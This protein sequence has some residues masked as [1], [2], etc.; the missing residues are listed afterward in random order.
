MHIRG[1]VLTNIYLS[2]QKLSN[3][4]KSIRV[5]NKLNI[6][7]EKKQYY[8]QILQII[9]ALSYFNLEYRTQIFN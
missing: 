1:L 6:I 3:E 2:D 5:H 8:I 9:F 7:F 4:I